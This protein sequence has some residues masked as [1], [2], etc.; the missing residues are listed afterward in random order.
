M[1]V[2]FLGLGVMGYP[3]AGTSLKPVMKSL[4]TT[5]QRLKL[6]SG[7]LNLADTLRQRQKTR[8]RAGNRLPVL[9]MMI[10]VALR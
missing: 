10:C 4:C 2:A 7:P 9:V 1:K 6:I 3:M 5:E 8:S